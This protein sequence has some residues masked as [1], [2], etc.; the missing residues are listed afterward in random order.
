MLEQVDLDQR[1][2]KNEYHSQ[3]EVLGVQ[4]G[5]LHRKIHELG[6]PVVLVFEGWDAAGRGTLINDLILRLDH[7]GL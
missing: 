6:I 2:N 1:L 7:G 5:E 4:L 3:M